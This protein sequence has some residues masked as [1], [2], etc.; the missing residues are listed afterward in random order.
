MNGVCFEI[1]GRTPVSNKLPPPHPPIPPDVT[2][3]KKQ[4]VVVKM[5]RSTNELKIMDT[6]G[7]LIKQQQQNN[8]KHCTYHIC[9][10]FSFTLNHTYLA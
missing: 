7:N 2:R 3:V 10:R 5:K 6:L 1:L 4:S 9:F 8:N